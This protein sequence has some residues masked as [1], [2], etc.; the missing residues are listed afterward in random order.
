MD[1]HVWW[2][3]YFILFWVMGVCSYSIMRI[4]IILSDFPLKVILKLLI[5]SLFWKFCKA[6]PLEN[7]PPNFYCVDFQKLVQEI[8]YHPAFKFFWDALLSLHPYCTWNLIRFYQCIIH[9]FQ[10]NMNLLLVLRVSV[11]DSYGSIHN[12]STVPGRVIKSLMKFICTS[13]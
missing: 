3:W 11:H 8:R 2:K 1:Y 9:G 7:H 5:E 13:G 4:L 6:L 10:W 12:I